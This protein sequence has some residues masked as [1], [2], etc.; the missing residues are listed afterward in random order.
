MI[1]RNLLR[2]V[3]TRCMKV[4]TR[5]SK[6]NEQRVSHYDHYSYVVVDDQIVEWGRNLTKNT[7]PV[8][9]GYKDFQGVH[10]ELSAY[11]KA[12]GL[13]RDRD[14]GMINVRLSKGLKL[15]NSAP[16]NNCKRML[17]S[18][19]GKWVIYSTP[20]GFKKVNL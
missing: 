4:S 11:M 20:D 15:L 7:P 13:L 9:W 8:H 10:S 17:K 14:F 1:S 16:C 12:V 6:T 19:G 2:T 3:L 5:K 18:L